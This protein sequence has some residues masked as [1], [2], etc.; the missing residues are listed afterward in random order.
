MVRSGTIIIINVVV[1]VVL[2][3]V[4]I[5]VAVRPYGSF[6]RRRLLGSYHHHRD[7]LM[8]V[9]KSMDDGMYFLVRERMHAP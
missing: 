5:V 4:A 7:S 1:A 9:T 8:L 6:S 2:S 3:V